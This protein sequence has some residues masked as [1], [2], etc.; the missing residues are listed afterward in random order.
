MAE[1]ARPQPDADLAALID[2][3]RLLVDSWNRADVQAFAGLF[4]PTAEYV[5]GVG[6]RLVGRQ[7]IARLLEGTAPP[8]VA[9]VGQPVATCHAASG[10]LRFAWSIARIGGAPRRGS[11]ECACI[12][13]G[14]R[15]LIKALQNTEAGD[16]AE[17][18]GSARRV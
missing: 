6:A 14:S 1:Q 15:W 11:I 18:R 8:P 3:A 13:H 4:T 2:V 7:A 10:D 9:L 12:R 16:S 17:S 5:T